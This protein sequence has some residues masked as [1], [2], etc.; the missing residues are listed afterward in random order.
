MM[1]FWPD[2]VRE[3]VPGNQ[4]SAGSCGETRQNEWLRVRLIFGTNFRADIVYVMTYTSSVASVRQVEKAVNCS[5]ET[6]YRL[7][8]SLREGRVQDLLK[9]G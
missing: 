4:T 9:A 7:W 2:I 1:L 3:C 6:A 8:H 5:H